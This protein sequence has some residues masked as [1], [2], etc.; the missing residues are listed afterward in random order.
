MAHLSIDSTP[1]DL[2]KIEEAA[3]TSGL[4]WGLLAVDGCIYEPTEEVRARANR[5]TAYRWLEIAGKLGFEQVR[6]DAGGPEEM[7]DAEFRT[8]VEGYNDLIARAKPMGM[9]RDRKSLGAV[10]DSGQC[11][12]A[13][14]IDRRARALARYAQLEAGAARPRPAKMRKFATATHVKTFTWD[15]KGNEISRARSRKRRSRS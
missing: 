12:E 1:D 13:V 14:R 15:A 7:P 10:P 9:H 3:D 8:I 4:P 2:E 6:I 5:Q 11:G